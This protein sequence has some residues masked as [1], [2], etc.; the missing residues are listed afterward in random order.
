MIVGPVFSGLECLAVETELGVAFYHLGIVK[1]DTGT[2]GGVKVSPYRVVAPRLD[3]SQNSPA[4]IGNDRTANS[5]GAGLAVVSEVCS[6]QGT[7]SLVPALLGLLVKGFG[8]G[9]RFGAHVAYLRWLRMSV[10]V[11]LCAPSWVR[12]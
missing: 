1:S 11:V 3:E 6:A 4:V 8:F 2:Y 12:A 5:A 7:E 9:D 10:L